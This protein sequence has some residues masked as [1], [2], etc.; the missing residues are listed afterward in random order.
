MK[1]SK[2]RW[3]AMFALVFLASRYITDRW[4][5]PVGTLI[6]FAFIYAVVKLNQRFRRRRDVEEAEERL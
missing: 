2:T 5:W 1:A 3:W 6:L 4:D